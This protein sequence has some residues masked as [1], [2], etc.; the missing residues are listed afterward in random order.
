M[1][2]AVFRRDRLRALAALVAFCIAWFGAS[3]SAHA[4]K[5]QFG[6][7]EYLVSIQP[8]D[9]KDKDGAALY[10]GYKYSHH[11]F[12]APYYTSDDGYILGI[13]GRQ[14]Y[15]K[16]D[17]AEISRL[18]KSG[19]LPTPLPTYQL[20]IWDYVFGYMLWIILAGIALF[21]WLSMRRDAKKKLAIPIAQEGLAHDRAGNL[22]EAIAH[23][24]RALEIDP[25]HAEVLG[26]RGSA[27]QRRG[28]LDLAIADFS[29][30]IA[31]TPKD[32][33]PLLHRAS[34]F[35][36]KSLTA[37]ALADY[38]RAV[39]VSKSATAYFL[40]GDLRG[41]LGD[42]AGTVDDMT[43]VIGIDPSAAVAYAARAQARDLLGQTAQA[44]ADRAQAAVLDAQAASR[45][46]MPPGAAAS[47]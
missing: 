22:D 9:L 33:T 20:S 11:S 37:Q 40:R 38:D 17:A 45:Q 7:T 12:L 44:E 13:V 39:K 42:P 2:S 19:Q 16:L 32:E 43:A 46:A 34:A 36:A 29:K 10:L 3:P 15:Y 25:K 27:Y 41:R 24:G 26:M 21:T 31:A 14:S 28:E 1:M 30:A 4:V 5:V 23:Y 47:A 35:E 8:L 18:Q 6:A